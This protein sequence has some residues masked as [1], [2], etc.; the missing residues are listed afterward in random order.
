MHCYRHNKL[1]RVWQG[2]QL[3]LMTNYLYIANYL[4]ILPISVECLIQLTLSIIKSQ[5]Y[6]FKFRATL[7]DMDLKF[8]T[9]KSRARDAKYSSSTHAKKKH[10]HDRKPRSCVPAFFHPYLSK[11]KIIFH[12]CVQGCFVSLHLT[13][14]NK[15]EIHFI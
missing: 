1:R 8:Y 9:H 11:W 3:V 12:A 15:L 13:L 10:G 7:N 5:H 6:R 4:Y 2:K 14:E